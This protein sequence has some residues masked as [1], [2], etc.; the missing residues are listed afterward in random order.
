MFRS[1]GLPVPGI[2]DAKSMTAGSDG[3][4]YGVAVHEFIDDAFAVELHNNLALLDILGRVAA[5][6][7][8]RPRGMRRG[9]GHGGI[10]D[11]R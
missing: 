9:G 6:G 7:D 4:G 10:K 2:V 1:E 11:Y 8:L 5:D 3:E